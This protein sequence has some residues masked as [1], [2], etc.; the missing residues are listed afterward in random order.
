[1]PYGASGLASVYYFACR[2]A[3]DWRKGAA[4]KGRTNDSLHLEAAVE[5]LKRSIRASGIGGSCHSYALLQ[6]WRPPYPETTGYI[7]KTFFRLADFGDREANE[8]VA[9]ELADWLIDVQLP[10]GGIAGLDLGRKADANV[11]NTGMVMLG[12]NEAFRR[13]T[14]ERYLSAALAGGEFLVS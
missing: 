10:S 11:F 1:M 2:A 8:A 12:W 13:S 7:L 9:H 3:V 4:P 6:G 14:D 5:F